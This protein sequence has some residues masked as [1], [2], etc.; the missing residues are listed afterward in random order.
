MRKKTFHG[1]GSQIQQPWCCILDE[2]VPS[3]LSRWTDVWTDDHVF[4]HTQTAAKSSQPWCC[5]WKRECLVGPAGSRRLNWWSR[6]W[7]DRRQTDARRARRLK[8]SVRW[9]CLRGS[10]AA[11]VSPA[12]KRTGSNQE[13]SVCI[14]LH[15][16]LLL[17]QPLH[18]HY[19]PPGYPHSSASNVSSAREEQQQIRRNCVCFGGKIF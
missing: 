14:S 4:G 12:Y 9:A 19:C 1:G 6:I 3:G 13:C 5:V 17:Q 2:G 10:R 7:A 18:D 11:K 16:H 8:V 15:L